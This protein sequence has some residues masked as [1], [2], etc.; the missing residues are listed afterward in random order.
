MKEDKELSDQRQ[1]R[2]VEMSPVKFFSSVVI[3]ALFFPGVIIALAG[4]WGWVEGWIFGLWFDVMVLSNMFYLYY[5]DPELL[6]E[7]RQKTGKESQKPWDKVL[8]NIIYL[9]AVSLFVIIPLD[10]VRFGWS[11]K[12]PLA[13]KVAGGVMLLP[14]LYFIY[15][16][17]VENTF[18]STMVRIQKE[19]KHRVITTGVYRFVRHPLYLGDVFMMFGAPLLA[20]SLYGLL[21]TCVGMVLLVYRILGEEKMLVEELDGYDEY[22]RKVKYRLI[23][24]LW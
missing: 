2:S 20:G 23:P 21:I 18:L 16:A 22:R 17:T 12:F 5:K 24:F 4:D 6:A 1:D 11:P 15:A 8:L 10:A 14:A 13:L 7:R 19:R 3:T 9:M